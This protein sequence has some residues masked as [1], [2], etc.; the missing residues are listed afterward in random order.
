[1]GTLRGMFP[2]R[3][4]NPTRRRPV[5]TI[6]LIVVNIAVHVL[7][8]PMQ[9][10]VDALWRFYGLFAAIPD[11]IVDGAE[12]T[13][14]FTHMFLHAGWMHL[15]GNMLFLWIFGDNLEDQLGHVRFLG[16]YIAGGVLAALC[17]VLSDSSSAVPLV[18]ASGAIAA[19]MGGY[20][21]LFPKARVDIL[22][23]LIVFFKIFTLRA[24]I[25]L[26]IW[27]GLQM[28][29]GAM[30]P[31]GVGG[32]AYWA[33]AG[34]FVAGVILILPMWIANG[35]TRFWDRTHG[36]PPYPET[37]YRRTTIPLVRR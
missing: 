37:V 19:V 6:A 20:L 31:A 32:V 22:L 23:I 28:V 29:N 34:G 11:H 14:L 15:G 24:W 2:I 4:H 35:G 25:V 26:A 8:L 3:D 5:V 12:M 21:V 7:T 36:H 33:H 10:D 27:F 9:G 17:Q 30:A 18:G 16:F 13:G 1:M